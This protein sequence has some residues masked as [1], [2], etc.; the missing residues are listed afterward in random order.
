MNPYGQC[1]HTKY[2]GCPPC[3]HS[4]WDDGVQAA[5]EAVT[6]YARETHRHVGI[7]KCWPENGDRCDI[8]AALRVAAARIF[9]LIDT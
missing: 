4:A 5:R 8:T 6:A 9:D 3:V 7:Q 1:H 2:E